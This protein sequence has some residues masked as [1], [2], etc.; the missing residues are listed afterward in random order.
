MT[1]TIVPRLT[2][3]MPIFL[4]KIDSSSR[5][6]KTALLQ[7]VSIPRK[8]RADRNIAANVI[9]R[10]NLLR[11]SLDSAEVSRG[12]NIARPYSQDQLWLGRKPLLDLF[13]LLDSGIGG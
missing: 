9:D 7:V 10:L 12:S 6:N 1:K 11:E 4:P 5:V 2:V 8:T 13:R 3:R